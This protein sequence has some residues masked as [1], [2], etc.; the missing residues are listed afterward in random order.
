MLTRIIEAV[1]ILAVLYPLS[2]HKPLTR[3]LISLGT[4][5][6]MFIGVLL[7]LVLVGHL[8]SVN[9]FPF[10]T[11]S[12]YGMSQSGDP[13]VY[14]YTGITQ[15]GEV[16]PLVP[17]RLFSSMAADRIVSK[18]YRQIGSLNSQNDPKREAELR[19]QLEETLRALG[20]LHNRRF[21][22]RQLE[23]IIVTRRTVHLHPDPGEYMSEPRI[24]WRFNIRQAGE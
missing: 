15:N 24:L 19:V 20:R 16:A 21:P 4:R 10:V 18:L 13:F 7:S 14:E 8:A 6:K 3:L 2:R 17:S 9:S 12:M 1:L 23:S 11:W 5:H 22:D